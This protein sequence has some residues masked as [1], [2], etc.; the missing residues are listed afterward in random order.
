MNSIILAIAVL[1]CI[2]SISFSACDEAM[3]SFSA[4]FDLFIAHFIGHDEI[5]KAVQEALQPLTASVFQTFS[6]SKGPMNIS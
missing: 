4:F 3:A 2:A 1:N 5:V 6:L